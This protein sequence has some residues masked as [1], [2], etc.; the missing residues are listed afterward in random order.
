[1]DTTAEK[2]KKILEFKKKSQADISRLVGISTQTMSSIM[3]GKSKPNWDFLTVVNKE[4]DVNLNWLIANDGE[5]YKTKQPLL[6]T[7]RIEISY[8]E[9]LPEN[10]KNPKIMS[11]W[12]DREIIENAWGMSAEHLCIIPMVGDKM[13]HYWYPIYNNDILIVDTS[14]DYIMGNGVYF[15]TS[16]N[17][18]RFWIREMQI[19]I[20][21]DVQVKGFAPSGDTTKVI[22]AD[23]LKEA[24][25]KIIGKVI[26]NVS[27]R[28]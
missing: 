17:N 28:L 6:T 10:L 19:L 25:F 15:A 4:L 9:E 1:M 18:T 24:D 27:F 8:W 21:N 3:N 5:P 2:I 14:Q 7:D 26:K 20:N 23:T 12:F 11:V 22:S 16:R 13:A